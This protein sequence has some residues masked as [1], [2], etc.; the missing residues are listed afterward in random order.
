MNQP[1][2]NG[3]WND[4]S[5][6]W[7]AE[8]VGAPA[9]ASLV[10]RTARARRALVGMRLLSVALGALALAGVAAPLYHAASALDVV[11][12]VA[13]AT[14]ICA[15]C[16]MYNVN[17]REDYGHADEPPERYLMLRRALCIRRIRFARLLWA[18]AALDLIFLFPWWAGGI[19]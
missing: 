5:D 1:T 10:E 19:R 16:L 9:L 18:L 12:G 11:I 14:G 6:Q 4:W 7:R 3:D 15:A 2:M 17:E 13:V 8:R